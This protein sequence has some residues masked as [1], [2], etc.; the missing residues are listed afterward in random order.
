MKLTTVVILA[1]LTVASTQV[2]ADHGHND[3]HYRDQAYGKVVHVEPVYRTYTRP[4]RYN[5][6]LRRD[7]ERG[8]FVSYTGTVLGAV[9][10]GALGHRIGDAHGDPGAAAIAGGLL[11]ASIGRSIDHSISYNQGLRVSGPCRVRHQREKV[12]ELVEYKVSY[13]YNGRV[14]YA[15]MDH[16]PGKWVKLDVDVSPA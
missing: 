6:C 3:R 10:G 16:D 5:S 12:R 1:L 4:A 15:R 11:G 13:R 9:V 14:H 8:H 2:F 7:P